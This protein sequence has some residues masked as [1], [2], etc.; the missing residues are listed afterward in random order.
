MDEEWR[1]SW[2]GGESGKGARGFSSCL[3]VTAAF[4]PP[5]TLLSNTLSGRLSR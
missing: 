1:I 5:R 2:L 3:I 4:L